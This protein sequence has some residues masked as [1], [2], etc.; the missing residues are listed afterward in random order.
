[1]SAV[2]DNPE[3]Y[4]LFRDCLS[5][6]LLQPASSAPE[7]PKRRRRGKAA[8]AT[9]GTAGTAAVANPTP[10]ADPDGDAEELAEFA[11]Y[12]ATEIFESLPQELQTLEFRSWR[13][14]PG[15]QNQYSFPL[16]KESLSTLN[17]SPEILETLTTYSLISPDPF[18]QSNL[19]S[20][21]E[22]FL[23]PILT[24]YLTPL[25]TPPPATKATR[26]EACEICERSWIPLSYHHLIPRFVH[27]KAVK[28]GWHREDD[29]QNVAW[30][31]GACHRFVHHFKNHEEL[32]RKYYTVELL[33]EEEED[34]NSSQHSE[35]T[36]FLHSNSRAHDISLVRS[37]GSHL[38]PSSSASG[39]LPPQSDYRDPAAGWSDARGTPSLD[40]IRFSKQSIED[41]LPRVAELKGKIPC[42]WLQACRSLFASS[43]K[44]TKKEVCS[45]SKAPAL[46]K[47]VFF[48]LPAISI[49][50]TLFALHLKQFR[51]KPSHPTSEELSALQF[52]AKAHESLILISLRHTA[53]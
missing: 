24:S 6:T 51:W 7:Q 52:A 4:A 44:E 23:L 50:M 39:L 49:T 40:Y 14:S 10:A 15:L 22:A 48:H 8:P 5:T 12:L 27:E 25:I 29:L 2:E 28:R 16:T 26:T 35:A 19:P 30:L 34:V 31:C 32:A 41:S 47:F 13:E 53:A 11:D 45:N 20:S 37:K 3:N 9:A 1:M 33:L 42:W 17:L 43:K 21:P 38:D 46:W 18:I 36:A